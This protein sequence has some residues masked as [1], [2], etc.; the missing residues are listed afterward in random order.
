M[1]G[2]AFNPANSTTWRGIGQYEL[3][4]RPELLDVNMQNSTWD[5]D[6]GSFGRDS[7]KIGNEDGRVLQMDNQTI[8][9]VND[10]TQY[11]GSLGLSLK[12]RSFL[13]D[14]QYPSLVSTLFDTGTIPS[15]YNT[16]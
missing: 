3:K 1:R 9:V 5:F 16:C 12:S 4:L 10:T 11:L 7:V 2:R 14:E 6:Y 8:A 13:A 15:K